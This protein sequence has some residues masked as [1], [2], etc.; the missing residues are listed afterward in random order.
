MNYILKY[1]HTLR[2]LKPSQ[3]TN[4]LL[5][6]FIK[7]VPKNI[8]ILPLRKNKLNWIRPIAKHASFQPPFSFTFLNQTHSIQSKND[9]DNSEWDKLWLYNLHYFDFL[10][11]EKA[12]SRQDDQTA[13]INKW[14][15][16]NPPGSGNGWEP[17]PLSIRIVNWIKWHLN[18]NKHS[19]DA[20]VSL[21]VQ[22]RYLKK[23]IEYHL[24]ANHLFSNGKALVFAGL[25]FAGKEAET[26]LKKGLS[27]LIREILEQ[28]L[29]D[30]GNYERSPMYHSI[31]LEDILDIFNIFRMFNHP[32]IGHDTIATIKTIAAKMLLWLQAMCHPD[33][34]IPLFNDSAFS[35]A[36]SSQQLSEYADHLGISH[37]KTSPAFNDLTETG[38]VSIKNKQFSLI[39]DA[40]D[41]G[42]DYQPGHAHADTLSFELSKGQ[43]RLIVDSGTST[44]ST[45][46]ERERQRGTAAHNTITI[47]GKNSSE[48]WGSFRVARRAKIVER[49]IT[50]NNG[51]YTITA[52]HNGYKR[53]KG[54]GLHR[55]TW[56]I[57]P[58]KIIIKDYI[59]GSGLHTVEAHFH[60]H[61]ELKIN[62]IDR[63]IIQLYSSSDMI[64]LI[65]D[66]QLSVSLQDSK[67]H[68][69]FG[70]SV[71]NK[72]AICSA[73]VQLPF[74][75]T[76][77]VEI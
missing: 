66:K 58:T 69:E 33:N 45:G 20:L 35:I 71:K 36:P 9:W 12:Q 18:G 68:P 19:E 54:T 23:K 55:R 61:P 7:P 60:F 5:R 52:A 62:G 76:T 65:C 14:T 38:Y 74:S 67:Y 31:M 32:A 77:I 56:I 15:I 48:V 30:G 57:S 75:F 72:K 3:V 26:W 49:S 53:L 43:R 4:R 64:S 13:L 28:V 50:E 25:F 16:E 22:T 8:S 46:L 29:Q 42:P 59:E 11:I 1:F 41:I 6:I 51:S 17:Y 10:C 24:M 44:Y 47:D 40:G 2:Y 63:S 70:L 37:N 27:I 73:K 21:A 34:Q 39:I